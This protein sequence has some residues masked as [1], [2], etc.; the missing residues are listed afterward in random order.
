MLTW[1]WVLTSRFDRCMPLNA[2][3]KI[4]TNAEIFDWCI[5][6]ITEIYI[7]KFNNFEE[8]NNVSGVNSSHK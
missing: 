7:V 6:Y 3:A 5:F 4:L 8:Q 2:M 1:S